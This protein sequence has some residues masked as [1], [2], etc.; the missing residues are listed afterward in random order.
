MVPVSA[1]P[2]TIF[3]VP[4]GAPASYKISASIVVVIGAKGDG[5]N[6]IVLPAAKAGAT[7]HVA[8]QNGKFHEPIAICNTICVF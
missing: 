5:L 8:P 3:R 1:S 4:G 2:C 7:F 6:I